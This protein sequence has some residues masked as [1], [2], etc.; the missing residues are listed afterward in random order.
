MTFDCDA[1]DSPVCPHCGENAFTIEPEEFN[2]VGQALVTCPKCGADFVIE[3]DYS[4]IY[5]TRK[6]N[7]KDIT[8]Q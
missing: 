8:K 7:E 1:T 4:V 6:S 2:V 5:Y 3:V